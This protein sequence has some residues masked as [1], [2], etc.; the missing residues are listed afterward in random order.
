MSDRKPKNY[1]ALN[2]TEGRIF[3]IFIVFILI[4]TVTAFVIIMLLNSNKNT[5]KNET[6]E[7]ELT[8][9]NE[10]LTEQYDYYGEHDSSMDIP[11]PESLQDINQDSNNINTD[12][13][14]N[15]NKKADNND[16]IKNDDKSPVEI[17]DSK[18]LYSSDYINDEKGREKKNTEIK[19]NNNY[20]NTKSN[21][22][23]EKKSVQNYTNKR[24]IVQIG[25]YLSKKT[26]EDISIYY[27]MQGYPVFINEKIS[28]EKTFY[29]LR[30]G[31]FKDKE[32]AIKYQSSLKE[33]KYGKD[34][35][36]SV[37]YL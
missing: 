11:E 9:E 16:N 12:T 25:S 19:K 10:D 17:D 34:S 23:D 27:K 36:V 35:Y 13:T 6:T 7:N 3:L 8:L 33:S 20:S 29:R 37:I 1:Y 26:A 24:Y 5:A 28:D 31:P 14:N 22:I 30:V 32:K 21:K 2:L 15:D 18:T 4:V